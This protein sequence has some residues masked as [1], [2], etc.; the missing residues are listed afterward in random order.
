MTK[1]ISISKH[2]NDE[3]KSFLQGS[4]RTTVFLRLSSFSTFDYATGD[5]DYILA[6]SPF[7]A[8]DRGSED[9]AV[10]KSLEPPSIQ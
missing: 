4:A 10:L 6:F 2:S 3:Y 8:E 9:V 1:V 5:A 7:Y